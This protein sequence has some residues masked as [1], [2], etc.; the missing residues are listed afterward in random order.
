M[1]KCGTELWGEALLFTFALNPIPFLAHKKP[2]AL[3]T[4]GGGS[5]GMSRSLTMMKTIS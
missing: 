5:L 1:T 2:S 3:E 4:S